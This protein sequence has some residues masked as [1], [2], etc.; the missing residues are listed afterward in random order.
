MSK[1]NEED[2]IED[3]QI[4]LGDIPILETI[5]VFPDNSIVK[6]IIKKGVGILPSAN[7]ALWIKIEMR[8]PNGK[9]TTVKN[10]RNSEY[11]HEINEKTN[12][13][14]LTHCLRT[15]LPL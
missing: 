6:K 14:F 10:F 11:K 8:Y 2:M 15:M 7:S 13:M 3:F 12:E 4:S 5:Q 1:F 9:L